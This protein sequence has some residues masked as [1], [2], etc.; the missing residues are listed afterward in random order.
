VAEALKRLGA[1]RAMV[2]CGR[3][4]ASGPMC[5]LSVSGP[6]SMCLLEAGEIKTVTL[7]PADVGLEITP[8]RELEIGTPAESAALIR[9][10]LGGEKGPARDIVL[11]NTAAALWVG[12]AVKALPQG[13]T[14]AA[15]AID[16]GKAS[17]VLNNLCRI[18]GSA[19]AAI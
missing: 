4:P 8:G 17:E 10:V 13:I 16:S 7:H 3:D 18:T 6:T 11:L 5:E 15:T 12:R 1:E 19:P 2:V 9:R 14:R